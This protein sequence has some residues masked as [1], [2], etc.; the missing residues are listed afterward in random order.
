MKFYITEIRLWFNNGHKP[1]ILTFLPNKINVITGEKSTGKSSTL[2]IIDYCLLSSRV[3]VVQKIIND[4]VSWYGLT[5][6]INDKHFVIVRRAPVGN[7]VSKDV[8][9]SSNG[10]I[11]ESP[12]ANIGID[13]LKSIIEA[14]F[15]IDENL[16]VPY[17]GKKIAAG[18]KISFRYFLLFN[19][20]S[21]DTIAHTNVFFD[22]E[23]YD[24]E[25]YREALN[26]IFFL[27]LG[28]D[29]ASNILVKEK[30]V[31]LEAEI[32]KI[33]KKEKLVQKEE[34]LF[35]E[36]IIELLIKAQEYDLIERSLML[37]EEAYKR[38]SSLITQFRPATYSNNLKQVED[39]NKRKRTIWRK[40]RNLEH[41]D[42]EYNTYRENLKR[43]YD[44]LLPIEYLKANFSELIP[45]LEVKSFLSSIEESLIKIRKEITN[46]KT[47]STNVRTEI[48]E[49]KRELANIEKSLNGLPTNTRDFTDEVGKF[50]FIG[51]L[52][53]QLAFYH[54]KWNIL[55]E[56]PRRDLLEAQIEELQVIL[57]DT[58]EKR[59][60]ILGVLELV[61]QKYFDSTHSM[62]VYQSYK[63]YFDEATK[64]LKLRDPK[65]ILSASNIG[66]K[67]NY[68]FLH[69]CLFFGLHEHFI[70][71]KQPYVPQFLLL[72]QPSQPYLEKSTLNSATGEVSDDDDRE[73]IK[74]AFALLNKFI[75]NIIKE[76][77]NSFQMILLEHA[78]SQYWENPL[79]EHF[80]LVEEYRNG[81]ALIPKEAIAPVEGNHNGDLIS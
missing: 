1:R 39:L 42:I 3:R 27:A 70:A 9:F 7:T 10:E 21:E 15:S 48:A 24:S 44:S 80:H 14:E 73:T 79:L 32:D 22:Y 53:S 62:G 5:F 60:N 37:P 51:E 49:L 36:K 35:N 76:Q 38:L 57:K 29:D 47:I 54:D 40:V 58:N 75:D 64:I 59:R 17:G 52:K 30:I 28:V 16:V 33:E 63:V 26:R 4:S 71:Q 55:E 31:A 67:S 78:S 77:K 65:E 69:L 13:K 66:S 50:I 45:T 6:S 43:D 61:I 34:R 11:P 8:Y 23:L 46:K 68:M 19:T 12:T 72:D 2:S 41:F 74:D 20:L 25:K 18:S 81:N 56:L